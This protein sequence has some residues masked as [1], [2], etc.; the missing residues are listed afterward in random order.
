MVVR[1]WGPIQSAQHTSL[2]EQAL[3]DLLAQSA[4]Q[5]ERVELLPTFGAAGDRLLI[6]LDDRDA[7]FDALDADER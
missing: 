6:D 7:V 4:V 1:A 3:R 2:V 5:G